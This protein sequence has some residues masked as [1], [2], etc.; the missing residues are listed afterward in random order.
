MNR[1]S[2]GTASPKDLEAQAQDPLDLLMAAASKKELRKANRMASEGG[3]KLEAALLSVFHRVRGKQPLE[4]FLQG[5]RARKEQERLAADLARKK[6]ATRWHGWFDGAAD[7]NPGRR[8]IGVVLVSPDGQKHTISPRQRPR[9]RDHLSGFPGLRLL[10][11]ARVKLPENF[12]PQSVAP[13][14]GADTDVGITVRPHAT[15]TL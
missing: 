1:S 12:P 9:L 5:R 10:A 14:A 7:P 4:A 2:N 8:S 3:L 13:D 6:A 15:A 11:I